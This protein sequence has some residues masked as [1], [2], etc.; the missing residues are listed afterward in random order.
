[1]LD[2]GP[3]GGAS[4][5]SA[6]GA[7]FLSPAS[8]SSASAASWTSIHRSVSWKSSFGV[9]VSG[10]P[11]SGVSKMPATTSRVLP[12]RTHF[13]R[14]FCS[15]RR[16]TR[17]CGIVVMREVAVLRQAARVR[18]PVIALAELRHRDALGLEPAPDREVAVGP[19]LRRERPRMF[20]RLALFR[21]D[22]VEIESR[23]GAE[24][25]QERDPAV[26]HVALRVWRAR[27]SSSARPASM[28]CRRVVVAGGAAS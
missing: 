9:V 12:E 4:G 22:E 8:S 17:L 13:L 2:A 26:F 25:E 10:T 23:Q 24:R 6:A 27:L 18:Q 21:P 20:F 15:A 19:H 16:I 5:S 1:M 11:H 28:T 14:A 7:G 3:A